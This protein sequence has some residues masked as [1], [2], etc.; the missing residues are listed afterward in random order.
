MKL[1]Q[2]IKVVIPISFLITVNVF[3][4]VAIKADTGVVNATNLNLREGPSVISRRIGRIPGN[5]V[6]N[7]IDTSNSNWFKVTYD[8]K[9]G[10]VSSEYIKLNTT[11]NYGTGTVNAT[12]LNVRTEPSL[13]SNIKTKL[14]NKQKVEIISK[15]GDW[16]K[17]KINGGEGYVF[18]QYI[19]LDSDKSS[20]TT[21]N[22]VYQ[23][24]CNKL[25]MRKSPS[26]SSEKVGTLA[27]GAKV[28]LI[29]TEGEWFLIKDA[30]GK[31]AYIHSDYVK[32]AT[33]SSST[34]SRGESIDLTVPP[35]SDGKLVDRLIEYAKRFLGVKYVYGGASPSG[36]DCSGFT[37]YVFKQFGYKLNR[38]SSD[39][40]SNGVKVSKSELYKGDLV[41][42]SSSRGSSRIGH[43]GIYIGGGNFIHASSGSKHSVIISSLNEPFYIDTYKTARR[44]LK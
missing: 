32:I 5:T 20:S 14:Y 7:V 10:Y 29:K 3:S 18:S 24:T 4:S 25:N 38:V 19:K 33:S 6:V 44:V 17:I 35:P 21:E 31:E 40:A 23:V 36:F 42:F 34:S 37:S 8:G 11:A 41:F 39:Q 28:T 9:T 22:K 27:K 12:A 15:E 1:S 13:S 16:Y 2:V 26:T 30:N 43:V